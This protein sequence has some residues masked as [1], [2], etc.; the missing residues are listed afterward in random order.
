[1]ARMPKLAKEILVETRKKGVKKRGRA[2][3]EHL[4]PRL[5]KVLERYKKRWN[6]KELG[7]LSRQ[8]REFADALDEQKASNRN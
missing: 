1:M 7:E 3:A 2:P 5:V 4:G 8:L 6:P